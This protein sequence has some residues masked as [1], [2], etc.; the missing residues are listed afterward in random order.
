VLRSSLKNFFGKKPRI[1]LTIG[2]GENKEDW[3][4]KRIRK[5]YWTQSNNLAPPLATIP[6][7]PCFSSTRASINHLTVN[8]VQCRVLYCVLNIA[9]IVCKADCLLRGPVASSA[10]AYCTIN[11]SVST[12]CSPSG[13]VSNNSDNEWQRRKKEGSMGGDRRKQ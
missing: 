10:Q 12:F 1:T 8:L 4:G 6:F 3:E 9:P 13:Q 2:R 11:H 5:V 7:Y